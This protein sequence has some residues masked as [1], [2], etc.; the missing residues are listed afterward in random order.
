MITERVVSTERLAVHVLEIPER[1]GAP[2][3]FVHGNLSSSVFFR[4]TMVDLP[5]TYRPFAVDLRGFG[6]TEPKPVDATRGLRDFADDV[7]ATIG[8]LGL[9]S[10]HLVGWSLGGGVVMQVLRDNPALVRTLT[11]INPVSPYGYGGTRGASG[12]L[13]DAEGAGTGAGAA[14]PDFVRLLRSG[15]R[16]ADSPLSPRQ[17]MLTFYVKPPFQPTDADLFVDSILSTRVGEDNYPGDT[18]PTDAWPGVAPGPR[19]VLNAM[20]PNHFRIDDLHT[21]DPKPPILWIRG[22]DDQI[23]SDT[24]M[25]DLAHLGQ[26]GAVPDWPGAET[27]PPQPMVTQTRAVLDQYASAGGTYEEVAIADCGHSPHLEK[28][29]EFMAALTTVLGK[30]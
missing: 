22:T 24:S 20:S 4:H 28:P 30:G 7:A 16:S 19:G 17:I 6:D 10:A 18:V 13:T 9:E 2:V 12:E 15:D 29:A 8:A 14:N 21:V 1:T 11:L 3:I 27:H 26:L 5:D 25:F 23:V